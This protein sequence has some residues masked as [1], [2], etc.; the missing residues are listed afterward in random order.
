MTGT[1][2][3]VDSVHT[4]GQDH[5]VRVWPLHKRS[6]MILGVGTAVMLAIWTGVGL[7]YMHLLDDGPVGDADRRG[8]RWFE[9]HRTS[10]WNTLSHY[11]SM[12]SDTLVKVILVAT[13]GG[14]MVIIWRRWHDGVF[15]AM[16]VIVEASVFV[17]SAFI[18][19]RDRPPVKH[20]DPAAP[21]GSFPSGH[22][23]AAVA[24]YT[25]V[26]MVVLWHTR[27]RVWRWVFGV[28]GVMVPL[29]VATS[30]VYR[31]MH[32]PIDVVAGLLLGLMALFVVRAALN[33][34]VEEI[35]RDADDSVPARLRSLDLTDET[36]DD[37]VHTSATSG[38]LT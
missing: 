28:I 8:A 31:G 15:L 9:E 12:M 16:A 11:G 10:T 22:T 29:I 36:H 6:W 1:V 32:H 19:D 17:V 33:A 34:G 2:R 20:L 7:L 38:V 26:L 4:R 37:T 30:R 21:S 5:W 24:F 27:H 23:G 13:V 3:T 35:D 14:A 18:V 25:G